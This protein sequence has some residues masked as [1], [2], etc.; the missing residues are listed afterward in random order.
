MR[1]EEG[2][3]VELTIRQIS[4]GKERTVKLMR[5]RIEIDTV[6]GKMP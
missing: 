1:G 2:T 4:D 3:E 6:S 5:S